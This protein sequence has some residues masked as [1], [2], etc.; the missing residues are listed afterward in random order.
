MDGRA[1]AIVL[2]RGGG[3]AEDLACF[4]DERVV[5]AI[6]NCTIA[7]IT[8][9]GHERDDFL[10]D[11][12]ADKRPRTPTAAAVQ[13]LPILADIYLENKQRMLYLANAVRARFQTEEEHWQ[14]LQNRIEAIIDRVESGELPLEEVFEQFAVAVECLQECEKFLARGKEQMDLSIELLAAEP[15]F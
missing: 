6:A 3:S 15:D 8:G 2:R 14:L 4:N 9:I 13:S 10:A 7:I 11:L 12:V 5:R 1:D